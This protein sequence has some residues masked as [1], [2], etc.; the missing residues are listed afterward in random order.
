MGGRQQ[1]VSGPAA[2]AVPVGVPPV[3]S[4]ES[5]SAGGSNICV[6]WN[7]STS[8][9]GASTQ[10]LSAFTLTSPTELIGEQEN[11]SKNSTDSMRQ[12]PVGCEQ[13]QSE[14]LRS[15]AISV[16]PSSS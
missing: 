14:Q 7:C 1:I 6:T 12:P 10:P 13:A 4:H 3:A 2:E 16:S 8:A 5:E 15:S 9:S 11:P